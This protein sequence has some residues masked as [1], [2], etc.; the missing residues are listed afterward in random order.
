[1]K[2]IIPLV[3]SILVC[4]CH[5]RVISRD[6]VSRAD[7]RIM[8]RDSSESKRTD[9]DR[10]V[11]ERDKIKRADIKRKDTDIGDT[12][13]V[14]AGRDDHPRDRSDSQGGDSDRFN[15]RRGEMRRDADR[16]D[17]R[18]EDAG[19]NDKRRDF[20]IIDARR[21]NADRG[22]DAKR[23]DQHDNARIDDSWIPVD[24]DGLSQELDANL[25]ALFDIQ[26]QIGRKDTLSKRG[27]ACMFIGRK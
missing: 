24:D 16:N 7:K 18:R 15:G 12:P 20:D 3:I 9:A 23:H 1:M 4:A 25:D 5:S 6:A 17:A 27:K 2:A 14:F 10:A 13:R 21:D 22:E 26:D 19:R 11:D 8:M